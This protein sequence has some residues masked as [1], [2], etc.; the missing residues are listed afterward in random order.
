MQSWEN[1]G[2]GKG[3]PVTVHSISSSPL[4]PVALSSVRADRDIRGA[5]P[6]ANAIQCGY[7]M[8]V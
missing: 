6:I 7:S 8:S 2:S 3:V 4:R 1:G 5:G